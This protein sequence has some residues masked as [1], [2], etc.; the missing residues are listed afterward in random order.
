[1]QYAIDTGDAHPR[2]LP[3]RRIPFH[4]REE[5]NALIEK[6]LTQGIITPILTLGSASITRKEKRRVHA[7]TD[8]STQ[9]RYGIPSLS[10]EWTSYCKR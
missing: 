1:M 10:H 2:R 5:L 4:F 8:N 3:A 7:I 9:S 6:L